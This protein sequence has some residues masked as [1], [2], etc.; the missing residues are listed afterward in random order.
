MFENDGQNNLKTEININVR[1]A[2]IISYQLL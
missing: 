2:Y 1:Q